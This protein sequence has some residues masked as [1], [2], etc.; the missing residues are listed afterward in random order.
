MFKDKIEYNNI[1]SNG[2]VLLQQNPD[3]A[4]NPN[5]NWLYVKNSDNNWVTYRK[6]ESWEIMQAED[7][8]DL[9]IVKQGTKVRN[10]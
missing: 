10:G 3:C 2:L 5:N 7:Q 6:L 9:C 1:L 4:W 8:R